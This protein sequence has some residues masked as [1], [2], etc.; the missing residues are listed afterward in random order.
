MRWTETGTAPDPP[1]THAGSLPDE[2]LTARMLRRAAQWTVAGWPQ[3]QAVI[4]FGSR[5]S[6]DHHHGSDRDI[7]VLTDGPEEPL[8][9]LPL[10]HLATR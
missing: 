5:A 8:D 10:D 1:E 6:G 4:L 7:A 3:V 9:D 2:E